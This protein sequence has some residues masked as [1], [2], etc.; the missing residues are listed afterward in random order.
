MRSTAGLKLVS[1][2]SLHSYGRHAFCK[3]SDSTS[4]LPNTSPVLDG[5]K[6][7]LRVSRAPARGKLEASCGQAVTQ[8]CLSRAFLVVGWWLAFG[9]ISLERDCKDCM[10]SSAAMHGLS[11][12]GTPLLAGAAGAGSCLRAAFFISTNFSP[13]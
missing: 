12:A 4:L 9:F 11:R 6:L 1:R 8:R 3:Q 2:V 13:E 10:W 7:P 5:R